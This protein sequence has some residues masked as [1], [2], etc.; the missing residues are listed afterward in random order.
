MVDLV[1]R[2]KHGPQV[3]GFL[4]TAALSAIS[5]AITGQIGTAEAVAKWLG[6]PYGKPDRW[7]RI[8]ADVFWKGIRDCFEFG[9]IPM[10]PTNIP[11]E[12][13]WNRAPGYHTRDHLQQHEDC[14]SV[15][16]FRP[17]IVYEKLPVFVFI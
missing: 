5:P 16:V 10:Q 17:A 14:L 4:D 9:H 2:L 13:V 12:E 6:I 15:N 7:S 3:R 1:V 11:L 8:K